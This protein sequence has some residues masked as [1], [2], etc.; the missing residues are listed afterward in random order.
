MLG[1]V[2]ADQDPVLI[3]THGQLLWIAQPLL[4][5]LGRCRDFVKDLGLGALRNRL[6]RHTEDQVFAHISGM[7]NR[8]PVVCNHSVA[9]FFSSGCRKS[10]EGF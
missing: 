8:I 9:S 1:T 3:G 10:D 5:V 6:A 2:E 7:V 4:K